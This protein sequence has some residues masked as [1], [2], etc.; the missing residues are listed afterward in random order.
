MWKV[1]LAGVRGHLVRLLLTCLAVTLGTAFVAGS[2]VL[3]DSLDRTFSAIFSTAESTDA[4]VR[5]PQDD[6]D[7]A[8]GPELPGLEI[9]LA[10]D[11]EGLDGV[12]RAVP[13]LTG[14]ALL[15]GA[16]G[17]AVRSGG[18]P[19]Q[20]F[21]WDPD[22]PAVRLLDGRGVE[23]ADE[24]VVE[25]TTLERS[26]LAV[27]DETVVIVNGTPSDVTIVGEATNDLPTAGATVVFVE[28]AL[29]R[30]QFAP[31]GVVQS[32]LVTGVEGST[33]EEVVATVAP[34]VPD[35][36]EVITGQQQADETQRTLQEALGFVTT[37]L[38]VFAGVALFVGAF[39]I[40][41]TFTMLVAQRT[42]ELALLRAVGAS[43]G[44]VV[45]SV[46]AEAVL[47]G[48]AGA[49]AGLGL[50]V[51]LAAALQALVA[52]LFGLQLDGLPVQ[53][54]T[55]VAT[56]VVGVVV[57][58]VAAVLPARRA[59]ATAP[60]AAM[61]DD[62]AL[63]STTVRTRAAAGLG[64]AAGGAAAM[65]L[66]L[67]DRITENALPVL[68]TGVAAVFL[69]IAIASP[70]V[71]KPVVWLL[72]APLAR[73]AVGRLAQR[74]ALRNPR[75]TAATASALMVGVALVGAVSVLSSSATASVADIVENELEGE[76]VV[77][78]G[79]P[80]TIPVGVADQVARVDGVAAVLALPFTPAELDGDDALAMTVDPGTLPDLVTLTALEGSLD[81]LGEGVWLS[82]SAAEEVGADVGDSVLVQVGTGESADR[83]VLAVHEDSQII[84]SDVLVSAD[85]YAAGT[86]DLQ[87]RDGSGGVQ[88]VVVDV[89][90]GSDVA[91]VRERVTDVAAQY[92]TLSVLDAGEFTGEQT[93]QINTVLGLL[94][95]LLGL[96]LVI[97]T[98]GVVN[99]LALSV[100]ERTREIG[101]LRAIGLTRPQLRRTMTIESVATTVFGALLGVTLG[102]AFG[103][104]L[105]QELV[106][107][108]LEV[109][110]VPWPTV[111]VVLVGS[112]VVGVLAAVLPA[113][114]ATR[115]DVLRAITT[116]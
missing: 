22:D 59:S 76:L 52:S 58:A 94:Y 81:E 115:I 62:Q 61:R 12:D 44:Q 1:T 11:I 106:D 9:G 13:Q 34:L 49:A 19:S 86:A 8:A 84:G 65:A 78:D 95:A 110:S 33:Q 4:V 30:E 105:Q 36:A 17:T 111:V 113:W 2:F 6:D 85:V 87:S 54:R 46:L 101:L 57:T 29:A 82:E 50:G 91:E 32:I 41:N 88:Y 64:L 70:A 18:A 38:L 100:V 14:S 77:S 15:Q 37:F 90:D 98:L 26:G 43:R 71:S 10:E 112:A 55:V 48:L 69:G 114:R 93:A 99:T 28:A 92:L 74:N 89:A 83:E 27:G 96:S 20:G 51:G 73:T 68:G 108:G 109:L 40:F 31:T 24:V 66:V 23:A 60:V 104:A 16:D 5:L 56:F 25:E 116:D 42:R 97:A 79:G 72:T 53:P 80:P 102:L 67:T 63:P 75:R 21:A 107:D 39:I 7:E 35:G 103:V 45:R 3:T 47:V